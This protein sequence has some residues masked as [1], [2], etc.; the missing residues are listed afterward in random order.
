M[1]TKI[2]T[3][4]AANATDQST[5]ATGERQTARVSARTMFAVI[6]FGGR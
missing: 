6:S 3:T 4:K 2:I 1:N 5:T